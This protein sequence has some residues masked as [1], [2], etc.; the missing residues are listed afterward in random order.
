MKI[1]PAPNNWIAEF[2]CL[3]A[4]MKPHSREDDIPSKCERQKSRRSVL[5]RF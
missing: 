5:D 4:A 2:V 3:C 1:F